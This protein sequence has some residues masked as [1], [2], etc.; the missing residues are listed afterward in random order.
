MKHKIPLSTFAVAMLFLWGCGENPTVKQASAATT[1]AAAVKAP[2]AVKAQ[3]AKNVPDDVAKKIT[4]TLE[5]HYADQRLK[6]ESVAATPIK[7]IYEVVVNGKQI[8]YTNEDGSY[9]LVGELIETK[10]GRSLTEERK[11]VLNT[12]DFKNLP[13]DKAIKEVRG[14]GALKIAVFS[15]ADC[16]FCKRLEQEFAKMDNI[17]I[18]NFMM[19][20]DML[21][22]DAPRKSVQIW[23]QP[24]RAKAWTDWMRDGKTPPK[25]ADCDNP[26]KETTA[27]GTGFGFNGTPSIVFPN[28]KTQSGFMPMPQLEAIIKANQ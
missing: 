20:L 2:A 8:A 18:Y 23:C 15:D 11:A 17:T 13:F 25:V 1:D 10:E 12:V 7:G 24:D 19:P 6:V 5:S 4:Q 3:V 28:G 14:N 16:P 26:V 27:L 22:P 9:M 21:H